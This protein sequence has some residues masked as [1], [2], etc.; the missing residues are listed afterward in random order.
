[1]K[2]ICLLFVVTVFALSFAIPV[3]AG[4]GPRHSPIVK[5]I[6]EWAP[7]VVNISTERS[8]LLRTQ[9]SWGAYGGAMDDFYKQLPQINIGTLKLKSLG[10]GV[11]VDKG[12][13]IL[14]NTHVV[15]MASKIY[16]TFYDGT[17]AEAGIMASSRVDD[18]AIIKA[19]LPNGAKVVKMANDVMIGE[20]VIAVGNSFGLENSVTAGI[21]SGLNRGYTSNDNTV[22]INNLIQ[23]DA[24][25]NPGSS[26]GGLFNLDGELVGIN[27]AVAQNAQGIGFA[28]PYTKIK[29]IMRQYY[30]LI[31]NQ[32]SS[33]KIPVR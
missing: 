32:P 10:S 5:V 7:A 31:K 13:L 25:I 8:I 14:T 18:L 26:G 12:G 4:E 21:V 17:N 16:V 3:A 29:D 9:P 19:P 1:M 15:N 2:K 20:T 22:V 23:T 11:I 24:S 33:V 6:K 30:E 28:I 27:L